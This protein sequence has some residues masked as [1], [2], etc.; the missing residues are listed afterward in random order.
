MAVQARS[1]ATTTAL[2]AWILGAVPS[3][4]MAS[5]SRALE[6]LRLPSDRWS[7]GGLAGAVP[8]VPN[9]LRAPCLP[10][11]VGAA[12]T[13][14]RRRGTRPL[15]LWGASVLQLGHLP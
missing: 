4:L 12:T 6:P 10:T 15:P 13:G 9:S 7:P 2:A 5:T 14:T 3:A 8:S 11:L 1:S